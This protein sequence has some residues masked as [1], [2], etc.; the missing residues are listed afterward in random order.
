M[1]TSSLLI[2][3]AVLGHIAPANALTGHPVQASGRQLSR[4]P[5]RNDG[6][7]DRYIE[8]HERI[9][10]IEAI[11]RIACRRPQSPHRWNGCL[12][13]RRWRRVSETESDGQSQRRGVRQKTKARLFGNVERRRSV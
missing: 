13:W 4:T 8:G 12:R 10:I 2:A 11:D 5:W 3:L 1:R 9:V 6:A 7:H